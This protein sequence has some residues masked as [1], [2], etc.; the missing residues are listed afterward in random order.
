[1]HKIYKPH[2]VKAKIDEIMKDDENIPN[3]P[4]NKT[5]LSGP[6]ESG[7]PQLSY[8][9]VFCDPR[10]SKASFVGCCIAIIQQLTGINI[11]M[12]YSNTILKNVGMKPAVITGLIGGVNFGA[13]FGGL[14][15]LGIAG[16]KTILF[17]CSILIA[18]NL[19]LLG[20]LSLTDHQTS[21]VF[22]VMIFICLFEFSSGPITWLYMSEIMQDK[23]L[24]IATVLNWS[25]NLIVSIIVPGLVKSIGDANIGWI[26]IFV[27]GTTTLGTVF[28]ASQMKETKGK[29]QPEIEAMF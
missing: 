20:W 17:Y 10:Y 12:F 3:S 8:G 19:V 9:T 23:A 1:M 27:G 21:V 15:L 18:I 24:S 28:I 25:I 22:L 4:L 6:A 29:T 11:I 14:F 7:P 16:R 2:A 26:F 5:E 13:T